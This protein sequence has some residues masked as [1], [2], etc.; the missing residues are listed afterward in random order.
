MAHGNGCAVGRK[1]KWVPAIGPRTSGKGDKREHKTEV[2]G[3]EEETGR[4]V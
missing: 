2:R 1:A 4:E 3:S